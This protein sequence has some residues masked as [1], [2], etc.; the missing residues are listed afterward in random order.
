MPHLNIGIQLASLREPFKKALLTAAR[1]GADAVE[2]DARAEIKPADMSRTAIRQVRKMLED[3]NLR[4]S[5][6]TFQTRRGY[7]VREDLDRR[8]EATK[9]A[10]QMAYD[11]GAS[12]VVNQ[13][14][15]VPSEQT[16]P[17]WDM[18]VQALAD[19]GRHA[20][21]VGAILAAR[22]G[23]EDAAQL[24]ALIAALPPESIGVDLDPGNLIINGFSASHAVQ[25][26]GP[27][28]R[29][30]H[31][32]DG[33]RDLAIGRG[34][35]VPLGRG[36]VDFPEILGVLEEHEYHG[37]LTVQRDQAQDPSAEIEQAV[38]YLRNL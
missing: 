35:E 29:H 17:E 12:I 28:I 33:V 1:L 36:S 31:A 8:V 37:Y 25:Q 32:R 2:I 18:L 19:L 24:A 11:L 21:K 5:A 3:A 15:R 30:V 14:G 26:L 6:V 22:T 38:M 10:M 20:Q 9:E 7:N 34:L 4:V 13:I 16:G 27:H 23:S